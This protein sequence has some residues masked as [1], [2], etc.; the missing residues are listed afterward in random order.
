MISLRLEPEFQTSKT[1]FEFMYYRVWA[2]IQSSLEISIITKL[3]PLSTMQA[4]F[5]V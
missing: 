2:H 3:N 1:I 4:F 5:R